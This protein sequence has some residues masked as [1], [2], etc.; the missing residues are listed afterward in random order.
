MLFHISQYVHLH[1]QLYDDD[2]YSLINHEHSFTVVQY[3][4]P[5]FCLF[6][7]ALY[8]YIYI[9]FKTWRKTFFLARRR[10]RIFLWLNWFCM[11]AKVI[12]AWGDMN[13]STAYISNVTM[14]IDLPKNAM[15]NRRILY[16]LTYQVIYINYDASAYP[17][18]IKYR[19]DFRSCTVLYFL[20]VFIPQTV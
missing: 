14:A 8:I 10:A 12:G 19:H 18:N 5:F 11:I 13:N 15:Y 4:L 17:Y 1:I 16:S 6:P 9:R 3:C 2:I 20:R 7:H